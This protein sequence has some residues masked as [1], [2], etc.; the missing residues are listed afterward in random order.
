MVAGS[1]RGI[2]ANESIFRAINERRAAWPEHRQAAAA[3]KP[4]RFYCECGDPK[5]FECISL[6]S[7]VYEAVRAHPARFVV[8]PQ[9]VSP[10][11]E[12]VVEVHE[13]YVVVEKHRDLHPIVEAGDPRRRPDGP[14][15]R[16]F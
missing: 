14:E 1:R 6:T 11:V 2:A 16:R 13:G 15:D 5:C 4:L 7:T 9:Y 8:A 12:D 10:D 3:E